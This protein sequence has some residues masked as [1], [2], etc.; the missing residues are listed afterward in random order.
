MKYKVIIQQIIDV[1]A[2]DEKIVKELINLNP[3]E[4]SFGGATS[5]DEYGTYIYNA[6]ANFHIKIISIKRASKNVK[7]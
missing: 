2:P 6:K 5:D 4:L 3:P 7:L 1:E